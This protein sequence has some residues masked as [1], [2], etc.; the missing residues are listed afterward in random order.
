MPAA[1]AV[2]TTSSSPTSLASRTVDVFTESSIIAR[3]VMSP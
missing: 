2:F 3:T 1:R